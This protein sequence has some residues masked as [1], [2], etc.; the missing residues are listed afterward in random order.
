MPAETDTPF[1]LPDAVQWSE[2]MLLSP[3]HL[4]QN[5]IY[6][7]AHVRARLASLDPDSWG[8]HALEIDTRALADGVLM[9]RGLR[10]VLPDGL[11]LEYPMADER[12]ALSLD[13]KDA[14]PVDG[15]PLRVWIGV[16]RRGGDAARQ[17]GFMQ[18]Y[19]SLAG[20]PAVD[21]NTGG[22]PVPVPRLR[23]VLALLADPAML[24]RFSACP[25]L[26]VY[27]DVDGHI[28][29]GGYHPPALRLGALAF[30][31]EDGL[32]RRLPE[33]ARKV[34][35]KVRELAGQRDDLDDEA[36]LSQENRQHLAV[37]RHL[38][39][40]LP[41]YDVVAGSPESHPRA[42]YHALA[43]LVGQ[44]ASL[45]GDPL[46]PPL[47]PYR[48]SECD[49]QFRLAVDYVERKLAR[50]NTDMERLP[51]ARLGESGFARHVPADASADDL[52]IELKPRAGQGPRELAAW[53]GNARI[54]SDDLMNTLRLR[55]LPG[56]RARPLTRAEAEALGVN[57]AAALFLVANQ[58]IEMDGRNLA[59]LR[60]GR[61]MVIQGAADD[62]MPAGVLWYRW[63][64]EQPALP[65]DAAVPGPD[66]RDEGPDAP[67]DFTP[68]AADHE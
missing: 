51:F 55:R 65:E 54:A 52:V 25:L 39:A 1:A 30:L 62:A 67:P 46:P 32:A 19:D 49:A 6:W 23:P 40:A 16:P 33:L 15:A 41:H 64:R 4:Q 66:L 22:N 9:V 7:H 24:S 53:L 63:K 21:E 20:E 26:E 57:P 68:E 37:A 43:L 50:V 34:S 11:M 56:A 29:L 18:R 10:A 2:G 35:A 8:L 14:L 3:Q 38:A 12:R 5:D 47:S 42:A 31:G 13:L 27:R 36:L 58:D 60:A 61:S 28:R 44:A 45:G 48:H 59:V 17:D